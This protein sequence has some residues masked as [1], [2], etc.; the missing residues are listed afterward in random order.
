MISFSVPAA[1]ASELVDRVVAVVNGDIITLFELNDNLSK[2]VAKNQ[3]VKIDVG[4]PQFDPLR[5]QL[6]DN[7]VN[8]HL[9]KQEAARLNLN[10][11][12]TEVQQV[13]GDIKKKN[14]MNEQQFNAQLAKEGLT[15][16]EFEENLRLDS[17]KKR[18]I[19]YMVNRKII[20]TDEEI[21]AF[22]EANK[23]QI[24]VTP[25]L[26]GKSMG[27]IGLIMTPTMKEAEN[28]RKMIQ[29]KQLSFE[30]AAKK[31]S[32]GP[33]REQGGYLG[34][35]TLSDLAP[36]LRDALQSVPP[37]EVAAPVMLDGKAVLLINKPK[38]E[39]AP[40]PQA[41]AAPQPEPAQSASA[42]PI[43]PELREQIYDTLY[44]QKFDKLFLAYMEKL[45]D[46][47]VVEIRL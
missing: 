6:L 13:I 21:A 3:G 33:G 16:K 2:I 34:D 26:S 36:V 12:D 19:G 30:E 24:P 47:S 35:V 44:K 11:T 23:G 39:A 25:S 32:L 37:G 14:G 42:G 41:E 9:L 40:K 4:D 15:R 1:Y 7:M 8:D 31:F 29:G 45:R 43:S 28:I 22:N 46:K 5:R 20:V 38:A 10:V 17:L 27:N 18:I